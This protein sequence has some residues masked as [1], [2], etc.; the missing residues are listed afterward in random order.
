MEIAVGNAKGVL[1]RLA[2]MLQAEANSDP[3]PSFDS[4]NWSAEVAYN[5]G[6]RKGLTKALQYVIITDK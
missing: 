1:Q 5:L 2:Q 4:P 6:Y 3:V